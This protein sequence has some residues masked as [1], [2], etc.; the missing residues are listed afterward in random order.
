MSSIGVE[1]KN[2]AY[3]LLSMI[4]KEINFLLWFSVNGRRQFDTLPDQVI[5]P[6]EQSVSPRHIFTLMASA[7]SSFMSPRSIRDSMSFIT[8]V[9]SLPSTNTLVPRKSGRETIHP[10]LHILQTR[11]CH[12]VGDVELCQPFRLTVSATQL[13]LLCCTLFACDVLFSQSGMSTQD[14][15]QPTLVAR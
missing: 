15:L 6:P 14:A 10:D 3:T 13:C 12:F 11:K 8:V 7:R 1:G 4:G 5:S 9:L 2:I